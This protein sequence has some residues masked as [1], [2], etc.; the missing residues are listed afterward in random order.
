M[1]KTRKREIGDLGEGIVCKYFENKGYVVVSRNYLKPW[2]EIDIVATKE[3]VW[4]F[5]EVKSVTREPGGQG[6]RP[7][8]NMHKGKIQRL[9]RVIQT[10]AM[11][12]KLKDAPWQM[13]LACVY[14][15]LQDKRA[16]VV[17]LENIV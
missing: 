10:Y 12:K 9:Y 17:V 13:D 15:N 6:I 11:E 5:I 16:R 7:E 2:G 3:G 4:H 8:E 14:I 1:A